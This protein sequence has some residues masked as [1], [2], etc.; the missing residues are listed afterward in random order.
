MISFAG[1]NGWRLPKTSL[2]TGDTPEFEQ[3]ID[4]LHYSPCL[5]PLL[6]G[7]RAVTRP[8][9][10]RHDHRAMGALRRVLP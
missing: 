5:N 3:I 8:A 2:A 7:P 4:C 10:P 1:Q 6:F 9:D